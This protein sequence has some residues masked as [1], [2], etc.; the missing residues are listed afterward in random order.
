[1]NYLND[2]IDD[3]LM[4][5]N[6]T[7]YI[8]KLNKNVSKSSTLDSN[9]CSYLSYS[10][11]N[12]IDDYNYSYSKDNDDD[13]NYQKD[14]FMFKFNDH[15]TESIST[16]NSQI[17]LTKS[18]LNLSP[19]PTL[20]SV[21][22][23]SPLI[24][25]NSFLTNSFHNYPQ[26]NLTKTETNSN[27]YDYETKQ[28]TIN[29]NQNNSTLNLNNSYQD[30]IQRFHVRYY[31]KLIKYMNALHDQLPFPIGIG[32][33]Q[34]NQTVL[35]I[36]LN[37]F[38]Q[39]NEEIPINGHNSAINMNHD[40]ISSFYPNK[41]SSNNNNNKQIMNLYFA[42]PIH[43]SQCLFPGQTST[44][45]FQIKTKFPTIWIQVGFLF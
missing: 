43:Y 16:P 37:P 35:M 15:Q 4:K 13:D 31:D 45:C 32:L 1:M 24:Y 23:S 42:C 25:S 5:I 27:Y 14:V 41:C 20:P 30:S 44:Y 2:K 40:L 21:S 34:C 11:K 22:S 7:K 29:Q 36:W 9:N 10:L 26:I 3:D 28:K 38:K 8:I 39:T 33:E 6:F 19:I 18:S 12:S 17:N